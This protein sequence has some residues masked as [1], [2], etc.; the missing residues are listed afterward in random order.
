MAKNL[1]ESNIREL[2]KTIEYCF[3]QNDKL[4]CLILLYS[5]IDIMSWL[6]RDPHEAETTKTDF[7]HWVGEFLLPGS[8]LECTA[9]ELYSARCSIIHAYIP[10]WGTSTNVKGDV[11]QINYIWA[12][13]GK[14]ALENGAKRSS[15]KPVTIVVNIDDFIHALKNAIQ[16]FDDSLSYNRALFELIDD[17]SN[18]FFGSITKK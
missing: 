11:N 17:R 15:K 7:I 10:E 9:E 14:S 1:Y 5:V 6:S 8:S 13:A 3:K 4:S 2:T 16:R 12:K 18:K